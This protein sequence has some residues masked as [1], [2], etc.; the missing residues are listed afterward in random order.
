MAEIS[1]ERIRQIVREELSK[2]I[3]KIVADIERRSPATLQQAK[4]RML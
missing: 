1:E 3:P 4:A 2:I